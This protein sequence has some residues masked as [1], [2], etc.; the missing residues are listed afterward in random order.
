MLKADWIDLDSLRHGERTGL[1]S[2][3]NIALCEQDAPSHTVSTGERERKLLPFASS[4]LS[5]P[6]KVVFSIS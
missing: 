5:F 6:S 4:R 3:D 1:G 2:L